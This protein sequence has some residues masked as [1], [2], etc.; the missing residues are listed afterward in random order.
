MKVNEVE[1]IHRIQK[2]DLEG[3]LKEL[4]SLCFHEVVNDICYT[5]G[6]K[7]DGEDIFQEAIL[8]LVKKIQ[9]GQFRQDSTL[10]TYLKGIARNMWASEKRTR[11]RR[12][13][14]ENIYTSGTNEIEG[15]MLWRNSQ[16]E[17]AALLDSIGETCKSILTKFYLEG[18]DAA[19][20]TTSFHFKNIQILR[21]RKSICIKRL[22]DILQSKKN[23]V[24][25]L[26]NDS[27]YE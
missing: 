4:Y 22:R 24:D 25:S 12:K 2:D 10:K 18:L 5:G 17:F 27:Y 9:N 15:P 13:S 3:S 23:L 11:T 8:I 20:I 14:R 6:T 21:N 7:D 16:K 26:L 1:I 19:S